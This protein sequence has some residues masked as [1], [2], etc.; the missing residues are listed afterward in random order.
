MSV[1]ASPIDERCLDQAL[2]LLV[3]GFPE[4]SPAFW[5]QALDALGDYAGKSD[6]G[7]IGYL[8]QVDDEAVGVILTIASWRRDD[9]RIVN[10]SSWYVRAEHR[11]Q[12]ARMLM[13]V[14]ADKSAIYTDISPSPETARLNKA[15]GF[16]TVSDC[17]VLLPLPLT[18]LRGRSEGEVLRPADMPA[19]VLTPADEAMLALHHAA[20][21]ICAVHRTGERYTP[22]IFSPSRRY[23]RMVVRLIYAEDGKV[24]V[25]SGATIARFL[26]RSGILALTMPATEGDH[27]PT[28]RMRSIPAPVQVKGEWAQGRIDKAY[29]EL[30]FLHL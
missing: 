12:A 25:E 14:T 9:R 10:L 6:A 24:M 28:A 17:V 2:S 29:S 23:G 15:L 16:S 8:M 21:C 26:L 5:K 4:R 11:W 20:G 30:V 1:L 19:G 13:Q 18:A 27:P 7:P 22:L 3:E